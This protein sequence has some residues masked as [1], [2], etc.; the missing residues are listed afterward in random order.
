[1]NGSHGLKKS[2]GDYKL[3]TANSIMTND[4]N[5]VMVTTPPPKI[6]VMKCF[7]LICLDIV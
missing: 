6:N 2:D 3:N 7:F 5:D 1:M 4:D